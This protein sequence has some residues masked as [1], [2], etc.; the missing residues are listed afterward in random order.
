MPPGPDLPGKGKKTPGKHRSRRPY[1]IAAALTG[2][3]LER[4]VC[5]IFVPPYGFGRAYVKKIK[6]PFRS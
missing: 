1:R 6:R 5:N 4:G 3:P 2:H